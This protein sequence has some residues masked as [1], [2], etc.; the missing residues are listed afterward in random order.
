M[1]SV[2]DPGLVD[3]ERVSYGLE[4]LV[5]IL[6]E[7]Y[8]R[9]L[10]GPVPLEASIMDLRRLIRFWIHQFLHVI[11]EPRQEL[12]KRVRSVGVV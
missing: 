4:S 9:Q 3:V 12:A 1:V 6:H 7:Y 10:R 8:V 2:G 5:E 11:R